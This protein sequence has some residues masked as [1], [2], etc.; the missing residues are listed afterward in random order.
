[1]RTEKSEALACTC[2]C[3]QFIQSDK[4][5]N[6]SWDNSIFFRELVKGNNMHTRDE[7][8]SANGNR[9]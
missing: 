4:T 7:N 2:H 8:I 6:T 9:L 5:I 1:M 3:Y